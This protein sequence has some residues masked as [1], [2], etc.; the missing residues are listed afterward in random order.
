MYLA[1]NCRNEVRNMSWKKE[2]LKKKL[3]DLFLEKTI[4][5]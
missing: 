1:T 4:Y 2:I 3:K 5:F